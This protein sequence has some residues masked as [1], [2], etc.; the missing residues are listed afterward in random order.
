LTSSKRRPYL[1]L[2]MSLG[3][4]F[5]AP[6]RHLKGVVLKESAFEKPYYDMEYRQMHFEMPKRQYDP[7]DPPEYILPPGAD[8]ESPICILGNFDYTRGT[9]FER[10]LGVWSVQMCYQAGVGGFV[11]CQYSIPYSIMGPVISWERPTGIFDCGDEL[12]VMLDEAAYKDGNTILRI[13]F[14]DGCGNVC[15]E[16]EDLDCETDEEPDCPPE[17]SI[18]WDDETSAS[19][20]GVSTGVTVAVTGGEGPY[21]WSVSGTG[22]SMENSETSGTSNTLNSTSEACGTATI[23]VTD[24]CD[25]ATSGYVLCT[26]GE[27]LE[28]DT[29]GLTPDDDCP[30][31]PETCDTIFEQKVGKYTWFTASCY[32]KLREEYDSFGDCDYPATWAAQGTGVCDTPNAPTVFTDHECTEYYYPIASS[33]SCK[34]WTCE[35]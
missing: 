16:E 30:M 17:I 4:F 2:K 19:S 27:W 7:F 3:D 14:M 6:V 33:L 1:Q 11:N 35:S 8:P 20:I 10:P 12:E 32:C 25:E 21:D 34:E 31:S 5:T 15:C 26:V 13:C 22:F 9:C 23:T 28:V 24:A 18:D 29:V